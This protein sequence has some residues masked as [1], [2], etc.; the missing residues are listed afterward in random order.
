VETPDH[1]KSLIRRLRSGDEDAARELLSQSQDVVLRFLR[2]RMTDPRLRRQVDSIDICQSVMADFFVRAAL[3]QFEL[4][5]PNQL[6]ALLVTMSRN[7]LINRVSKLPPH[8]A[9]VDE[10]DPDAEVETPS[11]IVAF[12]ELLIAFRERLSPENRELA[13][14]RSRGDTWEEIAR[15][16]GG[17]PDAL[18]M[19]LARAVQQV[20]G[21]LGLDDSRYE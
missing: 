16:V 9:N 8:A 11:E 6:M 20:A 17:N 1:F 4:E 14:R 2:V 18:R 12:R 15:L 10:V 7:R 5:T 13:D 19:K 21:E 3:G